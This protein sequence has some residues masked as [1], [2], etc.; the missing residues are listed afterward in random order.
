[1]GC[2]CANAINVNNVIHIIGAT[3][4]SFLHRFLILV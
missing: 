1:M 2:T 3:D 4:V